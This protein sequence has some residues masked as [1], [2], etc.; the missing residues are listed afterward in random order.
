MDGNFFTYTSDNLMRTGANGLPLHYD[1]LN[2]LA[3]ATGAPA[4]RFTYDGASIVAEWDAS[5]VLQRRYVHAPGID[6]PLVRYE[7]A[8]LAGRRYLHADEK[9][10][11]V[12]ES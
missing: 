10:S 7:G 9:G 11:I 12:A 8:G 6:E 4:T 3:Q 2:R 1:P 5:N